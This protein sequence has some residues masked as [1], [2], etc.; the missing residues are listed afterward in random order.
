MS[1]LYCTV[2]YCT[3]LYCTVLYCTV[4]YCTVLYCPIL[5]CPNL[6]LDSLFPC[7]FMSVLSLFFSLSLSISSSSSLPHTPHLSCILSFNPFSVLTLR[8]HLFYLQFSSIFSSFSRSLQGINN[9][10]L[11][12]SEDEKEGK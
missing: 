2:L 10:P 6:L 11:S 8:C 3:V 5:S 1:V 4:L 12:A 9:L 7:S